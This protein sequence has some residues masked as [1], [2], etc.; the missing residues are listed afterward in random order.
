MQQ[1][2]IVRIVIL[3]VSLSICFTVSNV[4]SADGEYVFDADF[5]QVEDDSIDEEENVSAIEA[6]ADD[7]ID[8][9]IID[10]VV[11]DA[12]VDSGDE[13]YFEEDIDNHMDFVELM[14]SDEDPMIE[15]VEER[16]EDSINYNMLGSAVNYDLLEPLMGDNE[17]IYLGDV[18]DQS[19]DELLSDFTDM[20]LAGNSND[21]LSPKKKVGNRLTGVE[22]AI[23]DEL[24]NYI[25][26]VASGER[27]STVFDF[28]IVDIGMDLI[29]F[30][31]SD[32]GIE[33]I[34]DNE[35]ISQD[36]IDALNNIQVFDF[37][38]VLRAIML[39]CPFYLYW[40]DKLQ[41]VDY[42]PC[43][44]IPIYNSECEEY[45][46]TFSG[47]FS[48]MF[49]VAA[50]YAVDEYMVNPEIG[51]TV[52]LATERINNIVDRYSSY[53]DYEKLLGYKK[54][55]CS[56]VSYNQ[57]AADGVLPYGNPWQLLWVFDD[58]SSTNVVCEGYA[59]AFQY[60]CDLTSFN[61]NIACITVT[62]IMN[63]ENHEEN[64]MW[65]IITMEDGNNYLADITNC[66]EGTFGE[67]DK[68]FLVGYNSGNAQSY[69]SFACDNHTITYFYDDNTRL[70]YLDSELIIH[71]S[72]YSRPNNKVV[73]DGIVY[74]LLFG[75]AKVIGYEGEPVHVFLP[76]EVEGYPVKIISGRAFTFCTSLK[77][78]QFP[79]G[80]E[81]IDDGSLDLS[82]DVPGCHR[83]GA[84]A[85]CTELREVVIPD[86]SRLNY[87]GDFAFCNCD[88]L[89]RFDVPSEVETINFCTFIDCISLTDLTLP[90]GLRTIEN[91]AFAS[92]AI[93]QLHIPASCR[94]IS[95][96]DMP[97]TLEQYT[98]APTSPFYK[99]D[100]GVLIA[101]GE[102]GWRLYS[103]PAS[104]IG[105]QYTVPDYVCDIEGSG[106]HQLRYLE[107]INVRDCDIQNIQLVMCEI[108]TS[109]TNA[110]I[111]IKNNC[112]L[113]SDGEIVIKILKCK[114]GIINIP[115]GVKTIG[116]QAGF[117][118]S[119]NEIIIPEGVERIEAR[120]FQADVFGEGIDNLT[121]VTFPSTLKY[122]GQNAFFYRDGIR[123]IHIDGHLERIESGAFESCHHLANVF[124]NQ[125][126]IICE[127]AFSACSSLSYVELGSVNEIC[128][129]AFFA[130]G[131]YG[132]MHLYFL[133]NEP[134]FDDN[135]FSY[136]YVKA[137]YPV[138]NYTWKSEDL[139]GF[140]A[141]T[142][143]W[144][145]Y[146]PLDSII[147]SGECAPDI[148][149]RLEKD[150]ELFIEGTGRISNGPW[151][152]FANTIFTVIISEGITDISAHSFEWCTNMTEVVLPKSL[153][154]I[155]SDAFT[156]CNSL[157]EVH[158]PENVSLLE[159]HFIGAN[160]EGGRLQRIIVDEK[161]NFYKD[162]D[163]VLLS[164]DGAVLVCFPSGRDGEYVVPVSVNSIESRAFQG[165]TLTS[166]Y[167]ES[168]VNYISLDAFYM[169][170]GLQRFLVDPENKYYSSDGIALFTKNGENLLVFPAKADGVYHVPRCVKRIRD[171]AFSYSTEIK[172]VV[173]SGNPP[174]FYDLIFRWGGLQC[175]IY[176]PAGNVLWTDELLEKMLGDR[177]HFTWD[178]QDTPAS[179]FEKKA[180][181]NLLK[182]YE[183][184]QKDK[185]TIDSVSIFE[186][187][188][189]AGKHICDVSS[190]WADVVSAYEQIESAYRS[191][192]EKHV[193]VITTLHGRNA[194]CLAN[195]LTEGSKCSVCGE[196]IKAQTTIPA[197]GHSYG[198]W[199]VTKTATTTAEG[200]K[201][202]SCSRCG[203]KETRPIA[204]LKSSSKSN[205]ATKAKAAQSMTVKAKN[206]SVKASKLK[207][208]NQTIIKAKAFTITK[209]QGKVTFEKVSGS[210]K[211]TITSGGKITVAKGTKKG[212]YRIKVMVTAAGNKN[213]KAG[214]K[215][216]TV[217]IKVK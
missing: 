21:Q 203:A 8:P 6:E 111:N 185:Y 78:I 143:E 55:I 13:Q 186:D 74:E 154:S 47:S 212:T 124:I 89:T 66:D 193:H 170:A 194:T 26:K 60:L 136:S 19:T 61:E 100:D 49:P 196:I 14:Y 113:S 168:N 155:E 31:A 52:L 153:I 122:I 12:T 202:R 217:K 120:A 103:Y 97:L 206:P 150:G 18:I 189:K 73:Y 82:N 5:Q 115:E 91:S 152:E 106:L 43:E 192:C 125:V 123:E 85:Y 108:E 157:L 167:I 144:N 32:L 177:P 4:W 129:N 199:T 161:N 149:W 110:Y 126:D 88:T 213:Y 23:Y 119:Y 160:N 140:G 176:Y 75:S 214:S 164:K 197:L 146:S 184:V 198:A 90:E 132:T 165:T 92:T 112:V 44:I 174:A 1:Y 39:D 210:K 20:L 181:L 41:P 118:G 142:I 83:R 109:E 50:D 127:S 208:K 187:A 99:A 96:G 114:S 72:D 131:Q 162:E 51:Q 46:L 80:L 45:V 101:K 25:E 188:L 209:A 179:D 116:A 163:G 68:L 40:F 24:V 190:N 207:N 200:V 16:I 3:F 84:F 180:L 95:I 133:G 204:K 70:T 172:K 171:D 34:F 37:E 77:S 17:N 7:E 64:H 33:S 169:D 29:Y 151:N 137:F 54:E 48:Y 117:G 130:C 175:K 67:D 147:A 182:K 53:S 87:I 58:D 105:Q 201:T 11:L 159:P 62:G 9:E 35:G 121:K 215:T 134:V 139:K 128:A 57:E 81:R 28:D 30:T 79:I 59:K 36:A 93:K 27:V 156:L 173:F 56:S 158:I 69:Y 166:L 211:L 86:K 102:A 191:L 38:T 65:N 94:S 148:T 138:D 2:R 10:E 183:T 42:L 76:E 178:Y 104:K 195:G 71:S 22:K 141:N 107:R 205:P 145:N 98:V 135:T 216:V 63:D 15:T